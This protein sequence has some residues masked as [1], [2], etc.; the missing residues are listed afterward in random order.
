MQN[1]TRS[2]DLRMQLKLPTGGRVRRM[3]DLTSTPKDQKIQVGGVLGVRAWV[4]KC[5]LVTHLLLSIGK[6]G[7]HILE[8]LL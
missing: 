6:K 3:K 7:N 1:S 5:F 4:G 2:E 8:V